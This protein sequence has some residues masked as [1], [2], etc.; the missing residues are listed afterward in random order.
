MKYFIDYSED[1]VLPSSGDSTLVEKY[2]TLSMI[3]V[4]DSKEA[5]YVEMAEFA[6]QARHGVRTFKEFTDEE[7]REKIRKLEK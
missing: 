3:M 2:E 4:Y 6:H 1:E 7:M 5:M